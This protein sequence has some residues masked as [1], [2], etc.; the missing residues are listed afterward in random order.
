MEDKK[1]PSPPT[2]T[3]EEAKVAPTESWELLDTPK[4]EPVADAWDASDTGTRQSELLENVYWSD[5]HM[6]SARLNEQFRALRDGMS[7]WILIQKIFVSKICLWLD[8][9]DM[10]YQQNAKTSEGCE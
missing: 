3:S 9:L 7:L 10:K 5:L 4:D 6:I 2:P 1:S 8:W